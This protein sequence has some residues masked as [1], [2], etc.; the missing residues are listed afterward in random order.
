[1]YK[2][3]D[4][5]SINEVKGKRMSFVSNSSTS[6]FRVPTSSITAHF[7]D[8]N[9]D[10]DK[11]VE[12][13]SGQFFSEVYFGDSHQGSAINLVNGNVDVAAFCDTELAPYIALKEGV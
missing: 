13:G 7:A 3:G 1:M 2:S 5:Y 6:G 9:L 11:L 10:E 12:G 8:D 4:T